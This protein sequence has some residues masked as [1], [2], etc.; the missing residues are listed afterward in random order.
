MI[1]AHDLWLTIAQTGNNFKR[2]YTRNALL[3]DVKET[4]KLQIY[5]KTF[6][7]DLNCNLVSNLQESYKIDNINTKIVNFCL[8]IVK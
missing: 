5:Q 7:F 8:C 2:G 3:E 1:H 6:N 4:T